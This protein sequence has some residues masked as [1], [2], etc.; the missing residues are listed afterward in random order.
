MRVNQYSQN[1]INTRLKALP[2]LSLIIPPCHSQ[3]RLQFDQYNGNISDGR[4]V[5]IGE[6]TIYGLLLG[7]Q[8]YPQLKTQIS[9]LEEMLSRNLEFCTPE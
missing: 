8:V 5:E 1:L 9:R 2:S 3:T 6:S 4:E 7:S